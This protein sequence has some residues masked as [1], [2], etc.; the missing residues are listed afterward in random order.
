LKTKELGTIS[1]VLL[2]MIALQEVIIGIAEVVRESLS[3]SD[4]KAESQVG[5]RVET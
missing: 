1:V 4:I 2:K 5:S 3:G